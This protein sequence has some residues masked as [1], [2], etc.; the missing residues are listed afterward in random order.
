MFAG[1]PIDEA[2]LKRL[3]D[4]VGYAESYLDQGYIAGSTLSIADITVI[5]TLS[6]MEAVGYKFDQFPKVI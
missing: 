4:A 1:Q 5:V 6:N 2:K 3:D